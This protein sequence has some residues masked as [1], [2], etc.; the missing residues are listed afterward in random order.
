MEFLRLS[1]FKL[2]RILNPIGAQ[3]DMVEFTGMRASDA[4]ALFLQHLAGE[5][6]LSEKTI[7][8]YQRDLS[9]LFGF[10]TH[11]LETSL[12]LKD[13]NALTIRDFRAYLAFRQS[14]DPPLSPASIGRQ[15][16]A[17]RTFFKY[18][19]RRFGLKNDAIGLLKGPRVKPP[20]PKP[21]S[22]SGARDLVAEGTIDKRPWVQARNTAVM[23]LLYGAGLRVS[24]AL[25]LNGD[26]LPFGQA[27][28]ITGKGNKMRIVPI[29]PVVS[30]AVEKYVELCPF[31]L[32]PGTPLFRAIRGG[33]LSARQV[34][35]DIQKLR[36]FLG[37][38]ETATP[39]ALRHSFATHLMAGGGDLRTIQQLLGHE[40]LSTTQR[41][42]GVDVEGL[43]RVHKAAHPRAR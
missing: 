1:R 22:E 12:T 6:R 39:H 14:C 21:L 33:P 2:K 20:L 11:H 27:L 4:L 10:L 36:G 35:L 16:S 32:E 15:L 19:D 29:L 24:E 8:S 13:L 7:E 5:R 41:Y 43:R 17:F 23:M 26:E 42:T 37:L 3:E 25:S 40:N 31:E 34:Q 28:R 18:L 9:A 38:P 30:A